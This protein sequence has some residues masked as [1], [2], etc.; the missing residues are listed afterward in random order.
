MHIIPHKSYKFNNT[1]LS[2]QSI[3][4]R[5][6]NLHKN[7]LQDRFASNCL[8]IARNFRK[9]KLIFLSYKRRV[10]SCNFREN[11]SMLFNKYLCVRAVIGELAVKNSCIRYMITGPKGHT[12]ITPNDSIRSLAQKACTLFPRHS[13]RL[14]DDHHYR[15]HHQVERP[16]LSTKCRTQ[17]KG[18]EDA[19]NIT[20]FIT[21]Y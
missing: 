10:K 12:Y 11:F 14:Q 16:Q 2:Y 13:R 17:K 1:E 7:K 15:H 18:T 6:Y 20:I 9:I 3:R 19:F 5:R 8:K 4:I 21:Y